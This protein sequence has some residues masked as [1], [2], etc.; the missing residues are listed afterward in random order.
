MATI[1][2]KTNAQ[3]EVVS[4]RL[5]AC[6][7]RD[8]QGKQVWRTCTIPRPEG[9]TP[10]KE[11]KEIE[12]QAD[13]WEQDQ[14]AQYEKTHSKVDKD[15]ITFSEFVKSHWWT[16]HVMDGEHTPSSISF[17]RYT[18][19][20]LVSYFGAKKLKQI[21]A[22]A[23]KRYI[24]FL[25]KEATTKA[26]KPYGATT[27][28]HHFATL[29]NILEY[30]RRFHYIKDDPCRDLSQKEKPHR[31]RK[32]I[33]FLEPVQAVKFMSCLENES[34]FWQCL[35]NV[36]IT[37]G[38]RR[39]EAA[40]LQWG[41][42]DTKKL[43]LSVLRNVTLDIAAENSLYVGKT[44][45]GEARTVPISNRLCRLLLTF[46]KEQELKFQAIL[47]PSTFVFCNDTDPYKPIRPDSITRHVRKFVE[48]NGLPNVSPHDLRHS[49]AT[50]ALESGADL[51]DVQTLLGHKDPSTTMKF[52]AGVTEEKQRRTV[53]GIESIIA[54]K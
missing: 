13:A 40:A 22:E 2:K 11:E 24:R 27:R 48:R 32:T 1:D 10:K 6:V 51:K 14:K 35:M 29:R 18:S 30:A 21:D 28:Q 36:L 23:V 52:Y 38:L 53:E 8:D 42:L 12:R 26:G 19:N 34:L 9:L 45:T 3:G 17:F 37:T 5:R 16:D 46:K 41:D 7:G 31:E 54:I 43:E 47:P 33:D 20:N 49:A 15:K 39:G 25:N 50:L 4:Y 44:K